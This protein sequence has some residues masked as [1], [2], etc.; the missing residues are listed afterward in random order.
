M[1]DPSLKRRKPLSRRP[2]RRPQVRVGKLGVVR[3]TGNAPRELRRQC[4]ERDHWRCVDCGRQITWDVD[5]AVSGGY[6]GPDLNM[7]M[8]GQMSHRRAKR[9]NGDTLGNVITRCPPCHQKSHNAGG[10][11]MEKLRSERSNDGD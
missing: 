1:I 7:R 11:P 9:N 8:V 2:K 10:K 4:F 6:P 5:S 3:L